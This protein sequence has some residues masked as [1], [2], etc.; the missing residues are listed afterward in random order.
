MH[1]SEHIPERYSAERKYR[2]FDLQFPVCL[3]FSSTEGGRRLEGTSRNV[4]LGGVLISA[5]EKIPLHTA[6]DCTME[7]RTDRDGRS[8]RLLGRGSV[9]R[10][11]PLAADMGFVIA[12]EYDRPISHTQYLFADRVG[13]PRTL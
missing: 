5:D 2:R 13:I 7:L 12:V 3:D 10:V 6:V 8:L 9:V 1:E 11:E 4:S